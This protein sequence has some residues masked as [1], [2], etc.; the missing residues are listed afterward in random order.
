MSDL[1]FKNITAMFG[2]YVLQCCATVGGEP[3]ATLLQITQE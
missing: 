1:R 3:C 2:A